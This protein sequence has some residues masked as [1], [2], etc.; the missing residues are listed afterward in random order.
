[1]AL[2]EQADQ[3]RRMAVAAVQQAFVEGFQLVGEV[4]DGADP[5][6]ARTALEGV[7]ITLQGGQR[8][9]VVRLVQPTLQGLAG[10][11]QDVHRLLEED[12]DHFLVQTIVQAR[13]GR[14]VRRGQRFVVGLALRLPGFGECGVQLADLQAAVGGLAEQRQGVRVESLVEQRAQGGDP[15]RLGVDLQAGGHLVHHSDQRLVGLLGLGEEALADRQAAL[16]DRPVEVQQGLAELVDLRQLGHGRATPEGGQLLKQVAQLLALA[17]MLA[18][19]TQQVLGLQQDV[20]ALGEE[21]A[22]QLRVATAMLGFLAPLS[23][24]FQALLVQALD[25]FEQLHGTGNRR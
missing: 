19:A 16:L 6:H 23:G 1:M 12:L 24:Q 15:R 4:A 20:H 7:Q 5:G 10:A 14:V 8:R 3:R 17:R 22:D 11:F 25:A 18:P 9:V 21:D 2:L 13:I